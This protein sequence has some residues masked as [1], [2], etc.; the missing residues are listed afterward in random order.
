MTALRRAFTPALVRVLLLTALV[1]GLTGLGSTVAAPRAKAAA[2][3]AAVVLGTKA[4]Q[5]AKTKKGTPYGYGAAGPTRFDCSGYTRW[6]FARLGKRLP[7]SSQGQQ[8]ATVP[9][10]SSRRQ[11]GD[12]VFFGSRGHVYHVG[13]YAGGNRIWHS[14]KAGDRVR[15]ARI[16]TSRVSYGRVR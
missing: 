8:R 16:W 2:P 11:S 5:I 13:I 10:P 12:L 4:V 15:L 1:A 3:S 7:H 9:V 6:V 14:P